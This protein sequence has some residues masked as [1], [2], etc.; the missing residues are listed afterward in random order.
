MSRRQLLYN[1]NISSHNLEDYVSRQEPR[2]LFRLIRQAVLGTRGS[3]SELPLYFWGPGQFY[4]PSIDLDEDGMLSAILFRTGNGADI[5]YMTRDG[6]NGCV[7]YNAKYPVYIGDG[8]AFYS[9]REVDGRILVYITDFTNLGKPVCHAESRDLEK[10]W[11][12]FANTADSV[13]I[14]Y[15]VV[16]LR[17]MKYNKAASTCEVL[18]NVVADYPSLTALASQ[19]GEPDV[20]G[21]TAFRGGT[22]GIAMKFGS[23]RTLKHPERRDQY[24]FVGHVTM[25]QR[26]GSCYPNWFLHKNTAMEADYPR[27][28]YMY[29]YTLRHEAGSW[30]IGD[31]SCC[32]QPPN[33]EF[34]RII[35]PTGLADDSSHE[36]VIISYGRDDDNCMLTSFT[37]R[38]VMAMLRPVEI[39][40][41]TNYVMHPNYGNCITSQKQTDYCTRPSTIWSSVVGER[42]FSKSMALAG[43]SFDTDPFLFNPS[44]MALGSTGEFLV[45]SRRNE[46]VIGWSGVNSVCLQHLRMCITPAGQLEISYA[47]DDESTHCYEIG[48]SDKRGEDPRFIVDE[49]DFQNPKIMINDTTSDVGGS[50]VRRIYTFDL[51]NAVSGAMAA[52]P[53]CHQLSGSMEKNWGPFYHASEL[54]LVYSVDPLKVIITGDNGDPDWEEQCMHVSEWTLPPSIKEAL[55]ANG[56]SLRGGT[57]GL[58]IGTGEYLFVGH[59]HTRDTTCF[60]DFTVQQEVQKRNER[61]QRS[62]SNLYCIFFYTIKLH[63]DNVWEID[64][65]SCCSQLP[66]KRQNFTKIVFPC[67]LTRA[68]LAWDAKHASFI[69]SYGEQD[70]YCNYCAMTEQFIQYVLRPIEEWNVHNYIVDVNYF[71]NVAML[72]PGLRFKAFS[73]PRT[74]DRF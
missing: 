42:G 24:L 31:I 28:Y 74:Q 25:Y 22:R 29:F 20:A 62:Y 21:M 65:I 2:P 39:W 73:T 54:H 5:C 23:G 40:N 66:G 13:H 41:T 34:Y 1:A 68:K 35:F 53:L 55:T 11:G 56:L 58:K 57:P 6:D 30:R 51:N 49:D 19:I 44:I 70:M 27:L 52:V 18:T 3:S 46:D 43:T 4:N 12:P 48:P 33:I 36:R 71:N 38:E 17:I 10:N 69:V 8:Q 16:P 7:I 14:V 63:D 67:G 59:S 72:N 15:S 32:F 9:K 50:V 47:K 37:Y 26:T 60:P 61:Y 64:R 45:V